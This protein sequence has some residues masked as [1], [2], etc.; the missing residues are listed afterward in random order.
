MAEPGWK[1]YA[2][3]AQNTARR[4]APSVRRAAEQQ[5]DALRTSA[6]ARG[7]EYRRTAVA[8]GR[9]AGRRAREN[10]LGQRLLAAVRDIFVIAASLFVF[11][12]V[13]SMLGVKLPIT[14]FLV[15]MVALVAIRFVWAV[16]RSERSA[17]RPDDA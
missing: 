6:T 16:V 2:K 8:A 4:Q 14:W 7:T 3:A 9:V 15:G 11:Y 10:R 17:E 13:L 12:A 5:R 1:I